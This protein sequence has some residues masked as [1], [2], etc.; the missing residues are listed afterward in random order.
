MGSNPSRRGGKP[1]T[2]TRA[3]ASSAS[4]GRMTNITNGKGVTGNGCG[5]VNFFLYMGELLEIMKTSVGSWRPRRD[6]NNSPRHHKSESCALKPSYSS[7]E[8]TGQVE[9]DQE[10]TLTMCTP[11]TQHE[12]EPDHSNTAII[13]PEAEW[14][15]GNRNPGCLPYATLRI[16]ANIPYCKIKFQSTQTAKS[17]LIYLCQF[18]YYSPT[19]SACHPVTFLQLSP[20]CVCSCRIKCGARRSV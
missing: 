2:N 17:K 19:S 7:H 14:P 11:P 20:Q 12:E 16:S 15:G 13:M 6:P 3:P 4:I 18:Q 1:G 5:R 9:G 10:I 8:D